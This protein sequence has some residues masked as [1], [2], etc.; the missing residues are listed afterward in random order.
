[1]NFTYDRI[2]EVGVLTF[3][4]NLLGKYVNDL[5]EALMISIDNSHHIVLHLEKVS[6][7]DYYCLQTIF[8]ACR[9]ALKLKKRFTISGFDRKAFSR[10]LDLKP[11]AG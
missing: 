6:H 3:Q 8:S 1:M 11:I 7:I 4:G 2:G 5:K 10:G 9:V